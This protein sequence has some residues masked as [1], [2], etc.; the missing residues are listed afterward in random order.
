MN[1]AKEIILEE[2]VAHGELNNWKGFVLVVAI[3]FAVL[4]LVLVVGFIEYLTGLNFLHFILLAALL[5]ACFFIVR[6]FLTNYHYY[7]VSDGI[8]I[9]Q[10]LGKREKILA[11][12]GFGEVVYMGKNNAGAQNY[13]VGRKRERATYKAINEKTDFLATR[14]LYVLLNVSP[15]FFETIRNMKKS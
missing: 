3:V 10:N 6:F 15:E 2:K 11:S 12:F 1:D 8:I 4:A 9:T 7:I 13:T 14:E 5:V